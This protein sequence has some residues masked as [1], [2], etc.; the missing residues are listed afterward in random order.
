MLR[1]CRQSKAA[2][3]ILESQRLRPLRVSKPHNLSCLGIR[4]HLYGGTES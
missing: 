1:C 3:P 2:L 4:S